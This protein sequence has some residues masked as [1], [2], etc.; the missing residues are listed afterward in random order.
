MVLNTEP[1]DAWIPAIEELDR[2]LT[3]IRMSPRIPARKSLADA[4][5]SLRMKARPV[6]CIAL[7][8]TYVTDLAGRFARRRRKSCGA[9]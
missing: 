2:K 9:I 4:A 3:F 5:E 1:N 7:S 8:A 6:P